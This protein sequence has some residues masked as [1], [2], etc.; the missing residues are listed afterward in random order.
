MSGLD[1]INS[2]V[3]RLCKAGRIKEAYLIAHQVSRRAKAE[4]GEHHPVYAESLHSLAL[5]AQE[6]GDYPRALELY[7][8]ALAIHRKTKGQYHPE[9][10][11]TLNNMAE[12]YRKVG[13]FSA[14]E[15]LYE[16]AIEIDRIVDR[17]EDPEYGI[18]LNNLG[19]LYVSRGSRA[20]AIPLLRDAT[21]IFRNTVGE[22][23]P[24]YAANMHSVAALYE[25][26]GDYA[27]AARF[28]RLAVK[29][30]RGCKGKYRRLLEGCLHNLT[31]AYFSMGDY[32]AA[33]L[34]CREAL[35]VFATG[36]REDDALYA[37]ILYRAVWL[38]AAK[39][40]GTEALRLMRESVAAK[41]RHI[42]QVFAVSPEK[43]R[44]DLVSSSLKEL[45]IF[46]SLVLAH[47]TDSPGAV[48]EAADLVLRR[49][50]ISAEALVVQRS[51]VFGGKYPNLRPKLQELT[52]LQRKIARRALTGPGSEQEWETHRRLLEEWKGQKEHLARVS[53]L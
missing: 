19:T 20:K 49:K 24:Y 17:H 25:S 3:F 18:H 53:Y 46:L 47:V 37:G 14:A 48:G 11:A 9:I 23:H 50:G 39:G 13:N 41:D 27:G 38:L 35:A 8:E 4:L 31:E 6:K 29:I 2:V 45:D 7:Q 52:D 51:T 22:N 43:Q 12:L 1:N 44:M 42:G 28:L 16:Q 5:I 30:L 33:E 21:I 40:D 10:A 32:A 34:V 26:V 36:G 15:P